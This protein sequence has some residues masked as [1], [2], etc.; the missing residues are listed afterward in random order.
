MRPLQGV[1]VLVTR[2]EHQATPL[3]RLLESAGARV[4]R[5][6]IIDVRPASDPSDVRRKVGAIDSF[7]LVVFTSA[8]AVRFGSAL[9]D[10]RR[11]VTLA[12]IGPA[13]ARVLGEAGWRAAVTPAGGFDS[14]S[15]LSHPLLAN[16]AG[17]RVL[18]VKGMGG[19]NL[20]ETQLALRGAQVVV[21]DVYKRERA[22]HCDATLEALRD[23][24]AAGNIQVVTAT[25]VEIVAGLIDIATAALRRDFDRVHWLVPGDRV[26]AA[27]RER[28][29]AG[30]ILKAGTAADQDLLAAV[31]R[32]RSSLSEA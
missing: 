5:L 10:P 25:S 19:R 22:T 21:A 13:T 26:A 8:N 14:E 27:L 2:P 29:V 1:G 6:P 17:R 12:A 9:L 7:D 24:F 31:V 18:L 15:L 4:R 28:G 20:L 11:D 16:P 23:E 3:C 30:P 32:W